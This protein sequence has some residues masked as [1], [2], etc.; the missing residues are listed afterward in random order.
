[1]PDEPTLIKRDNFLRSLGLQ[2][3][4]ALRHWK[5]LKSG[6]SIMVVTY[7]ALY[8]GLDFAK[9]FKKEADKRKRP[10]IQM[11]FTNL[12][13]PTPENLK[14]Q[15]FK[16]WNN[17]RSQPFTFIDNLQIWVHPTGK[18]VWRILPAKAAPPTSVVS[19]PVQPDPDI[20]EIRQ[21]VKEYSERKDKLNLHARQ[22]EGRRSKLSPQEYRRLVQEYWINEYE[23]WDDDIDMILDEAI[24]SMTGQLTPQEQAEKQKAIDQLRAMPP[25]IQ[26]PA[27]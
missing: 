6:E 2:P 13:W 15:G 11:F 7:M 26:P 1:M 8:Y 23:P 17:C 22:L 27:E 9:H 3:A 24:P 4:E 10:D 12:P 16:C 25:K 21:Y 19:Q 18:E 5:R 20:E 14:K